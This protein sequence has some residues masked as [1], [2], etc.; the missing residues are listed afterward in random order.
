MEP[1]EPVE[2]LSLVSLDKF[3]FRLYGKSIGT[4]YSV[5]NPFECMDFDHLINNTILLDGNPV[6]VKGVER[7][8]HCPPWRKGEMIG[9][10]V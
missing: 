6:I 4:V 3:P 2:L 8:C 9:L 10:F 7:F 1:I 5:W